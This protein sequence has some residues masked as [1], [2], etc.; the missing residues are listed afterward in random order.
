VAIFYIIGHL[1]FTVGVIIISFG[2]LSLIW[3]SK[4]NRSL[5]KG[6]ELRKFT[7]KFLLSSIFVLV[8]SVWSILD[9]I[10]HWQG[11]MDY[12]GFIMLTLTFFM[13]V[14]AAFH[15]QK[16]GKKFGFEFQA[17]KIR[18]VMESKSK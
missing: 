9:D 7:E 13:F 5:S 3:T 6:S 4:A 12:F 11:F 10:F 2:V 15:I 17:A 14:F 8:Y 16:I 1:K 18:K